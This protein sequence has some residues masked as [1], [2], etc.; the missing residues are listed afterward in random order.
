[1]FYPWS[2]DLNPKLDIRECTVTEKIGNS[3]ECA[4]LSQ[5]LISLAYCQG[6]H[7]SVINQIFRY[8]ARKPSA[9]EWWL[10]CIIGGPVPGKHCGS[11]F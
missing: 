9:V 7:E 5:H 1:M 4:K 6:S 8:Q 11:Q 2:I 3:N 10:S